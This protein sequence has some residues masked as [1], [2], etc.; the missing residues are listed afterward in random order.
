MKPTDS[1]TFLGD[2]D[3]G[4]VK[5]MLE[6]LLSDVAGGSLDSGKIGEII[7]KLNFKPIPKTHQVMVTHKVSFK[8]PHGVGVAQNVPICTAH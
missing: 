7:L 4:T 6:R 2:L 3:A 5:D 1:N 8:Q